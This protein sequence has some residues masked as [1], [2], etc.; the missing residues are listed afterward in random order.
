MS[1]TGHTAAI[2]LHQSVLDLSYVD[3][4]KP[5]VCPLDWMCC[6]RLYTID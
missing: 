1:R 6:I 2:S 5:T 4:S 3:D